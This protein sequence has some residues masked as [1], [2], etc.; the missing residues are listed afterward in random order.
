VMLDF[1]F[2]FHTFCSPVSAWLFF[3]VSR[4]AF[5]PGG[6]SGAIWTRCTSLRKCCPFLRPVVFPFGRLLFDGGALES[7]LLFFSLFPSS[8]F[9]LAIP[10]GSEAFFTLEFQGGDYPLFFLLKLV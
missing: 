5:F 10:R 4:D 1:F 8:P 7:Y 9:S 3:L 6:A 2:F